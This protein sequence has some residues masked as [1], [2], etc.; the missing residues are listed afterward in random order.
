M[1]RKEVS[2]FLSNLPL[3][4]IKCNLNEILCIISAI[5][6]VFPDHSL[7][8]G[9]TYRDLKEVR[10]VEESIIFIAWFDMAYKD[11]TSIENLTKFALYTL[12][13]FKNSWKNFNFA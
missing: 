3:P 9:Y 10:P 4:L 7:I 11:F 8:N 13:V 6:W 2:I 12:T 5:N 1:E